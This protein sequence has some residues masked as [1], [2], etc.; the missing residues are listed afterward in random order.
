MHASLTIDTKAIA[1]NYL[2]MCE[3]AGTATCSA[4]IKADAYGLG[5]MP[6]ANAL[7]KVG[8]R[9]FF[10]ASC[11]E[12]VALRQALGREHLATIFVLHGIVAGEES[13]FRDELLIPILNT[14]EQMEVWNRYAG[15]GE[16]KQPAILHI[17][18]G[19]HRLGLTIEELERIQAEPERLQGMD[20]RLIMSHLA[21][22][23]E[24]GNS[25]NLRQLERFRERISYLPK[26]PY[27]LANSCGTFLGEE[28]RFDM[29]RPGAA[30]YGVNPT[31][32][33]NNPMRQVIRL[34]APVLQTRVLRR[35]ESVGYGVTYT[36]TEDRRIATLALGYADGLLRHLGNSGEAYLGDYVLPVRGR[37][38][39]DLTVV[40]ITDT[41]EG[42]VQA[43]TEV[44]LIDE[45]HTV[46]N[47]ARAGGT[48]GYEILT[49]LGMRYQREYI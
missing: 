3:A 6:V 19:M 31:P 16:E 46:G 34:T 17:D 29:V 23:D 9:H 33:D 40:D 1:S 21:C 41:P 47:L 24:E 25:K 26:A 42:M 36:A 14:L 30:L 22:A 39:M 28:Y 2:F 15:E 49:R 12:G 27:S 20:I 43:G 32:D 4:V 38:S 5:A 10:V 8:C 7:W 18:T 37:I 11:E 13:Y 48:I 44:T 45:Q 35:G